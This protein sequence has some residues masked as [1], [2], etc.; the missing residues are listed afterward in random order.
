[1]AKCDWC[2]QKHGGSGT[3]CETCL[4][5]VK[6]HRKAAFAKL[7][8]LEETSRDTTRSD[9][10]ELAA[11]AVATVG[12]LKKRNIAYDEKL[13]HGQLGRILANCGEELPNEY[14]G[15]WSRN[16]QPPVAGSNKAESPQAAPSV[17]VVNTP[18]STKPSFGG[19]HC[20]HCKGSNI[21]VIRNDVNMKGQTSLN[22][23]P[24]KPF[25]VF[26]HTKKEKTSAGKVALGAM[27][28]GAS[29]LFTGT[30]K[31]KHLE[32]LCRDCGRRWQ[33]K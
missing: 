22:L 10:S 18:A 13:I 30:K 8:A 15:F 33:S 14:K 3:Y 7:N 24:L 23:N 9:L 28:G 32:L 21:E 5:I 31:K 26:N 12:D 16:F 27:T 1:M 6:A 11:E 2:K 17:V 25:T 29:L 20:P 19:M 4:P